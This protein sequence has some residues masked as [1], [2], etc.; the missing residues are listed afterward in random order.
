M[1]LLGKQFE[2]IEHATR[3]EFN[4]TLEEK[5]EFA[6]GSH[7]KAFSAL[8]A[9]QKH[10][11]ETDVIAATAPL[12]GELKTLSVMIGELCNQILAKDKEIADLRRQIAP[13]AS[14]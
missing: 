11:A 8:C 5:R 12:I 4:M 10:S 2:S 6:D 7:R 13:K 1:D 9:Q 14:D 3:M